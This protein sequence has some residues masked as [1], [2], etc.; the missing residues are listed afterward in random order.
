[1]RSKR[2][3]DLG[4]HGLTDIHG[5]VLVIILP[6]STYTFL[7]HYVWPLSCIIPPYF[8]SSRLDTFAFCINDH[9][10]FFFFTSPASSHNSFLGI[11]SILCMCMYSR[12]DPVLPFLPL[13]LLIPHCH[14]PLHY[15]PKD[16]PFLS[17]DAL[18]CTFFRI[19]LI[20][21]FSGRRQHMS[22][23][24][25]KPFLLFFA[26]PLLTFGLIF[27]RYLKCHNRCLP[28]TSE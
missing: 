8:F 6:L 23:Q 18:V 16:S 20:G 13:V 3:H 14:Y 2:G 9:Y 26:S 24:C 15:S 17:F 5:I 28:P 21:R 10:V 22:Q 4:L 12:V 11:S 1:M 27:A 7:G 19:R 25:P